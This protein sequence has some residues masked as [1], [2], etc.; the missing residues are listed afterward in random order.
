MTGGATRVFLPQKG[1]PWEKSFALL[2]RMENEEGKTERSRK[3]ICNVTEDGTKQDVTD[4]RA[5]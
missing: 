2:K 5:E 4:E 3:R 1:K